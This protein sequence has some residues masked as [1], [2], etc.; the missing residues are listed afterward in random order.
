MNREL[1][2]LYGLKFNPFATEL[3]LEA[4]FATPAVE[5]FC[6]RVEQHLVRT[7]GFA[8]ITGEPGT[9]KSVALRL[10][11]LRSQRS[12]V[13]G[14]PSAPGTFRAP[15]VT[16]DSTSRSKP[17]SS[18]SAIQ[19]APMSRSPGLRPPPGKRRSSLPAFSR[20]RVSGSPTCHA[21]TRRRGAAP[22]APAP[23]ARPARRA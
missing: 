2:T 4:L 5:S 23:P 22:R 6:R 12:F 9:G 17:A 16:A 11:V 3:P 18:L 20:W 7:G 19:P 10:V 21:Y 14:T 8:L 1:L 13:R 15:A